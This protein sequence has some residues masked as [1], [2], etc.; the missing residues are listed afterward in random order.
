MTFSRLELEFRNTSVAHTRCSIC[1]STAV[2]DHLAIYNTVVRESKMNSRRITVHCFNQL[3]V[4]GV[5]HLVLS[6]SIY[7]SLRDQCRLTVAKQHGTQVDVIWCRFWTI[8]DHGTY[9]P[10]SELG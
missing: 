4:V 5:I 7:L 3:F 1:R 6:V 8:K 9:Q 2:P 10:R